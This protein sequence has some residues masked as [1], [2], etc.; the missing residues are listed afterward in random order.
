[1]NRIISLY[2][3]DQHRMASQQEFSRSI[4]R[5]RRSGS[6]QDQSRG[7]LLGREG[8]GLALWCDV[9]SGDAAVHSESGPS[10]VGG[11]V[12]RKEENSVGDLLSL[13]EAA[14]GDMHKAALLLLLSVKEV[15]QEGSAQGARAKRVHSDVLAGVD[16]SELTAHSEDTTLR[17]SVGDLGGGGTEEGHEGS[18]VDD[19]ATASTL[20]GG[21]GVAAAEPDTLHVDV[22]GEIPHILL[23]GHG[24][25]ISGV[26]DA[27]VVEDDVQ[28][29]KLLLGSSDHVLDLLG[30]G[31]IAVDVEGGARVRSVDLVRDGLAS[32][33]VDIGHHDLCTFSGEE[34]RGLGTDAAAS[35]S[36]D[37]N[38]SLKSVHHF[39][40]DLMETR[41]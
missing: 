32:L 8:L 30:L 12:R 18:D 24:V 23:S 38:L 25:V 31:D 9:S 29:A 13:T 26:H 28:L 34:A 4:D 41:K 5:E 40:I 36:D 15:H 33:V 39:R 10:N 19:A 17:R 27:G 14:H 37:G 1:M 7:F 2:V 16:H 22:H 3:L 11:L 35:T 20:Q 6:E 21:D